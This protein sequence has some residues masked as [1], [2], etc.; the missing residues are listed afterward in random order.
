MVLHRFNLKIPVGKV[1]ALCGPSGSGKSTIGQL[2]ERF[3]DPVAGT[4]TI[5]GHDI[6]DL[7][8]KWIRQNIGY[9]DQEP[10]LFAGSIYDNIRFGFF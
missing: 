5:D 9:I 3:Y 4:V 2:M 6:R 10:V 8:P 7:D 1:V